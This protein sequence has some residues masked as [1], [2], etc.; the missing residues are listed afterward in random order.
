MVG[1]CQNLML[2][3]KNSVAKTLPAI[4]LAE[5]SALLPTA[6]FPLM[7]ETTEGDILSFSKIIRII[8]APQILSLSRI[9]YRFALNNTQKISRT[10]AINFKGNLQVK[11][12]PTDWRF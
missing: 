10:R 4:G 3:R 5:C 6:V 2:T 9:I 8:F 12:S 7:G 11:L 1:L